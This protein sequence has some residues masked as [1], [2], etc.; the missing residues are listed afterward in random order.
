MLI[1]PILEIDSVDLATGGTETKKD[2]APTE[3]S[4]LTVIVKG[5]NS[6]WMQGRKINLVELEKTLVAQKKAFPNKVPQ[7]IHDRN[8]SFGTYQS[9]KNTLERCGFD[10]M[11]V[12]LKPG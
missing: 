1:A 4:P 8:A 7:V 3:S 12:V 6:I 9:V 11:D 10:Q 5:D 2:S